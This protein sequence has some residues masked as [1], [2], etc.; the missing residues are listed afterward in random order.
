MKIAIGASSFSE[1]STKPMEMLRAKGWTV[2]PN[3][4]G[5]RLTEDEIIEHLKDADGL[6]AGLEPLTEKVF[7]QSPKLKA[8]ARGD[9]ITLVGTDDDIAAFEAKFNALMA[10]RARKN[11]QANCEHRIVAYLRGSVYELL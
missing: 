7:Q 4:Y 5:R 9:G 10:K 8:I 3:P 1:S 2:V 6:L 11:E